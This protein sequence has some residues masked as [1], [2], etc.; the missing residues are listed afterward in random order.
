MTMPKNLVFIRHG[1][2]EANDIQKQ[3]E[4]GIETNTPFKPD[5]EWGLTEKGKNQAATIGQIFT[6]GRLNQIDAFYVSPYKRTL[7]TASSMAIEKAQWKLSRSIRERSWGD[8]D[9][10]P[11]HLTQSEYPRNHL[12]KESDPLY[13]MP[14]SGESIAGVADTRAAN[15]ISRLHR[16]HAGENVVMVTHHDFILA[17]RLV[18]E[19]MTDGEFTRGVLDDTL[20]VE[21]GSAI[22]YSR[23]NPD[24]GQLSSKIEYYK[25]ITPECHNG[26]WVNVEGPWVKINRGKYTNEQL[27]ELD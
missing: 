12:K 26:E 9:T 13:W 16:E 14:P 25:V 24:N 23:V 22:W 18:L 3:Q 2:S 19:H 10:V 20:H 11:K 5:R 1:Y 27:L 21:N 6:D 4:K 17:M 7:Q 8:I 15:T